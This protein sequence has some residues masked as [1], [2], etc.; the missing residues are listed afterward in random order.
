MRLSAKIIA[1]ILMVSAALQLSA[2][3]QS[4]GGSRSTSSQY[5][6]SASSSSSDSRKSSTTKKTRV[7]KPSTSPDRPS[8][9]PQTSASRPEDRPRPGIRPSDKNPSK[10][11]KPSGGRPSVTRPGN[12]GHHHAVKPDFKPGHHRKPVHHH[13]PVKIHPRERDFIHYS[14]PSHYWASHNHC[15]GHRVKVIPVHAHRHVYRGVTYYCH[16]NVW[17]SPY[18]GY[19]VVCRPP[20]GTVLAANIISDIVWTAVI[21]SQNNNARVT[22]SIESGLGLVQNYAAEGNPYYYQDGVFY[23]MDANGQYFVIAPPAGALVESLPEDFDVVTLN[24][25]EYYRVDNTIYKM[26]ISDGKPYFEVLGQMN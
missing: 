12:G 18:A 17:Y 22:H 11:S 7:V 19:Y 24:G 15:Y 10:P 13:K 16:D 2:E 4:R 25:K 26:T 5:S 9:T 14:K 3:A 23:T 8:R 20:F 1:A 6:R 21:L